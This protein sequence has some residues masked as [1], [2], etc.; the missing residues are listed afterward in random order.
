M[1]LTKQDMLKYFDEINDEL[2]KQNINGDIIIAGGAALTLV[3]G[4]RN[5]TMDI[6]AAFNPKEVFRDIIKS[7]GSKY[8]L[9]NDW[10]NDGVKGFFT[11]KMKVTTY[12]QYSNLTVKSM[13]AESLLAMKL[14]AARTDTKDASDSITLMKYLKIKNIDEVFNIIENNVYEN[15]L[16]AQVKFFTME[17]YEQYEKSNM[18]NSKTLFDKM[19]VADKLVK[20]QEKI[21]TNNPPKFKK[22]EIE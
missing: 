18:K 20:A 21:C 8:S 3:Y 16:T 2:K 19:K 9:N 5:S 17:V 1:E 13:D 12:K 15:R 4:A 11:E 7:I 22:H 6:D 10:L 14:T